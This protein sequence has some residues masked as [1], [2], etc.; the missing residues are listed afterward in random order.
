LAIIAKDSSLDSCFSFLFY[1]SKQSVAVS[2]TDFQEWLTM[3][4]S[5]RFRFFELSCSPW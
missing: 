3:N 2:Y 1:G 5:S 4:A